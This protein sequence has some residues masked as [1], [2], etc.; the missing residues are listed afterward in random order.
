M[1]KL[2][3]FDSS[4]IRAI[5]PS[6]SNITHNGELTVNTIS[7]LSIPTN[8]SEIGWNYTE[9][10]E[11][12]NLFPITSSNNFRRIG[13]SVQIEGGV[14][15]INFQLSFVPLDNTNPD[16]TEFLITIII[17]DVNEDSYI[18]SYPITIIRT[19]RGDSYLRIPIS[20]TNILVVLPGDTKNI[21]FGL[22]ALINDPL[23]TRSYVLLNDHVLIQ[24]IKIA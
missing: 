17:K 8:I 2:V 1:N 9:K 13:S 16:D 3:V 18:Y 7:F 6:F 21:E 19:R 23:L 15:F 4:G 12:N 20:I 5:D 24:I 22:I 14:Y 10:I 11:A